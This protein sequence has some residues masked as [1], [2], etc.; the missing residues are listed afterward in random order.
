M[1]RSVGLLGAGTVAAAAATAATAAAVVAGH[2]V[3]M[4]IACCSW[5][6]RAPERDRP[7]CQLHLL[8]GAHV[9][10]AGT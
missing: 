7:Y 6:L 8:S 10:T 9:R 4:R 5:M 3:W 1:E 2:Q